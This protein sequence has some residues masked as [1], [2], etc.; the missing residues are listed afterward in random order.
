MGPSVA[1]AVANAAF[2]NSQNS[3]ATPKTSPRICRKRRPSEAQSVNVDFFDPEGFRELQ[4]EISR[5]SSVH[6]PIIE[7]SESGS[8]D[9][10]QEGRFD[11]EKILRGIMQKYVPLSDALC[12]DL[13]IQRVII[14]WTSRIFGNESWA[15]CSRTCALLDSVQPPHIKPRSAHS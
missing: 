2:Q 7:D 9:T 8:D 15:S 10:L 3:P 5:T 4:R 12:D 1:G 11:L 14:G 13:F 6:P